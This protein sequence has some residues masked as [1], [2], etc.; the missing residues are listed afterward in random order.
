MTSQ[1]VRDREGQ[2]GRVPCE[3][4]EAL[5]DD[6]VE[7]ALRVAEADEA[8]DGADAGQRPIRRDHAGPQWR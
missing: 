4:H 6:V 7:A 5:A 2:L 3:Q 1:R 8:L